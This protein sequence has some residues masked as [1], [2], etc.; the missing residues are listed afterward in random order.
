[1]LARESGQGNADAS[2]KIDTDVID[3]TIPPEVIENAEKEALDAGE[4]QSLDGDDDDDVEEELHES[5]RVYSSGGNKCVICLGKGETRCLYCYGDTSVKIGP[6][7]KR[8]TIT[9][10]QCKGRGSEICRRCEGSGIRPSTRFDVDKWEYV[11]NVTNDDICNGPTW[12]EVEKTR[13]AAAEHE[14]Q[15][16]RDWKKDDGEE[17]TKGEEM[18]K[19]QQAPH[20]HDQSA[21]ASPS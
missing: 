7:A 3:P 16:E 11:A 2:D 1:M 18:Q 17:E 14:G 19:A 20:S 4:R 5:W 15:T 21:T 9:C 12:A 6:D 13:S 10:P 8:D